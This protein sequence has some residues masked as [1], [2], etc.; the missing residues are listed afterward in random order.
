MARGTVDD[1]GVKIGY[2]LQYDWNIYLW[3]FLFYYIL[4]SSSPMTISLSLSL[5]LSISHPLYSISPSLHVFVFRNRFRAAYTMYMN[6][7]LIVSGIPKIVLFQYFF[8]ILFEFISGVCWCIYLIL[9][10]GV[11]GTCIFLIRKF[12][13]IIII[14]INVVVVVL[15]YAGMP[16]C[17]CVCMCVFVCVWANHPIC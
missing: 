7:I 15:K 6:N 2:R 17:V 11:L 12:R 3:L 16:A 4:Q 9:R 1:I 14:I 5:S 10:D 13:I 8:M